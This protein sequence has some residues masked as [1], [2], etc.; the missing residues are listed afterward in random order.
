[1][2]LIHNLLFFYFPD[3]CVLFGDEGVNTIQGRY[4]MIPMKYDGNGQI[5][6][7]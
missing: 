2:S 4:A 3:M 1:M 5:V 6:K 7:L